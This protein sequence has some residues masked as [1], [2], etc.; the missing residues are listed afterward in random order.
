MKFRREEEW[1]QEQDE[2]KDSRIRVMN[3]LTLDF[4]VHV[5]TTKIFH[6]LLRR[7]LQFL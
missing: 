4:H 3:P 6:L 1:Q 2:E 7:S 5:V